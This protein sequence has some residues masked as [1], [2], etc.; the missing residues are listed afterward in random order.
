[1]FSDIG[2]DFSS[3]LFDATILV[4]GKSDK[5]VCKIHGK[6]DKNVYKNHRKSD[7]LLCMS[8]IFSIFAEN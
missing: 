8:K 5:N 1:M 4:Y 6:N 2:G 7:K 3:L